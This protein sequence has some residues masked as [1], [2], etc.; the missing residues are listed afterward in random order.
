MAKPTA[1]QI[2]KRKLQG[3]ASLKALKDATVNLTGSSELINA[4]SDV[5]DRVQR[6]AL[7]AGMQRAT[8]AIARSI[9]RMIPVQYKQTKKIVGSYVK[10]TNKSA[11]AAKAGLGVGKAHHVAVPRS[12]NNLRGFAKGV[13]RPTGVGI[14]GKNAHWFA[15]GTAKMDAILPDVVKNGFA[16]SSRT[17]QQLIADSIAKELAKAKAT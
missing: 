8:R 10:Q 12:G 15:M 16:I 3:Q 11:M 13:A 4:L 14:S 17:A 2:A 1:A 7:K 9:K 6:K 5:A